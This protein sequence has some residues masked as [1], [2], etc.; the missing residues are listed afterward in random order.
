MHQYGFLLLSILDLVSK[1]QQQVV[2]VHKC[3]I[4]GD[5]IA[6]GIG[7]SIF[8]GHES[9]ITTTLS[10]LLS[11]SSCIRSKW[12]VLNCGAFHF[13]HSTKDWLPPPPPPLVF[14]HLYDELEGCSFQ[15]SSSPVIVEG[16]SYKKVFGE[17]RIGHDADVVIIMAGLS[18]ILFQKNEMPAE[19]MKR[20]LISYNSTNEK[21]TANSSFSTSSSKGGR[22]SSSEKVVVTFPSNEMCSAVVN[23]GRLAFDLAYIKNKMV[24][25]VGF[26]LPSP[27]SFEHRG[28]NT[29]SSSLPAALMGGYSSVGMTRRMNVQLLQIINE[30]NR[31][32]ADSIYDSP[33]E[34]LVHIKKSRKDNGPRHP[35]KYIPLNHNHKLMKPDLKAYDGVHYNRRGYRSLCHEIFEKEDVK[36]LFVAAEW[37]SWKNALS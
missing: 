37:A 29:S 18:D 8:S 5:G 10:A 3:C 32:C 13:G 31:G 1:K 19:A 21:F 33:K 11:R 34:T 23:I 35:I 9:G 36:N 6:L 17:G 30:I 4:I 25:V 12:K 28:R 20:T 7:D 27:P 2:A 22:K 26:P 14:P 15:K 16:K 24:C